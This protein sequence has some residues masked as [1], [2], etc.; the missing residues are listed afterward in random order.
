MKFG[1][2]G[3]NFVSEKFMRASKMIVDFNLI[4]VCSQN[5]SNA[6]SFAKNGGGIAIAQS[7][8]TQKWL[9]SMLNELFDMKLDYS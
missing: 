3:T 4:A 7:G 6:E 5:I 8:F 2:I 1:I 9:T